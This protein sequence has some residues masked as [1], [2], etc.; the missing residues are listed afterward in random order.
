MPSS[1]S[2]WDSK[3]VSASGFPAERSFD[4]LKPQPPAAGGDREDAP[5]A[6]SREQGPAGGLQVV[7]VVAVAE[8]DGVDRAKVGGG[9]R[10]AGQLMELEPQPKL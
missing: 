7:A 8:Q 4:L 6:W 10:R 2:C 1:S 9:D 5:A 3:R